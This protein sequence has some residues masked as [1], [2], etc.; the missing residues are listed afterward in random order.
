M[1]ASNGYSVE[2]E[3]LVKRFGDFTAV[4][5]ISFQTRTGEVFG[6]LGPNGSGKSTTIRILCGLLHPTAGRAIV[7]GYDV[8]ESPETIRRN[9]GYMS[10]KFSLYADLTVLENLRFYA[11]M[12]GVPATELRGRIDW[13]LEMAGLRGR[14]SRL[15]GDLAGGW[16]QRLALGCAV[17]HRPPILFLDEPTSGVDPLSRR[18]FWELIQQMS[19]DGVTIFVT[20]HYMDEA[21]YCNRLA[22]MNGGKLIALGTPTELKL[23]S[24]KGALLLLECDRLGDAIERLRR[25]DGVRD[26]AVFGNALHLVVSDA[27]NAPA[28]R[29]ALEA[30]AISVADLRVIRPSLEDAF[31]A[32]TT[33][34]SSDPASELSP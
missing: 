18:L 21:E 6:F 28:I 11:G 19:S 27:A 25:F 20:T 31:V 4:D 1:M 24:I 33:R 26:V 9:I 29:A 34:R 8:V 23:G 22:L 14:E 32:L 12:Y 16:K 13:A 5:H 30:G 7:A 17:L 10:Q 15:T 3:N 2:V